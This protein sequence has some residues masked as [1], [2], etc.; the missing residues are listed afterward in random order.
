VAGPLWLPRQGGCI[1]WGGARFHGQDT[2]DAI[3]MTA[4]KE[5]AENGSYLTTIR[6]GLETT[7]V[8]GT[9]CRVVAYRR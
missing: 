6:A 7:Q 5:V 1:V 4:V 8:P 3:C 2:M 9:S